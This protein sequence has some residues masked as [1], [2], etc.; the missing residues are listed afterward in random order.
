[1]S[2]PARRDADSDDADVDS[3]TGSSISI[4]NSSAGA[5][6]CTVAI[7]PLNSARS[8]DERRSANSRIHR[9]QTAR[10]AG[11]R[12]AYPPDTVRA[13]HRDAS[14]IAASSCVP[15][16]AR[17]RRAATASGATTFAHSCFDE[18]DAR[19]LE[20]AIGVIRAEP[21]PQA[22]RRARRARTRPRRS[23]HCRRLRSRRRS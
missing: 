10:A 13:R 1:M 15:V 23:F 17:D 8:R 16:S 14:T 19:A 9:E 5:I 22:V 12:R 4:S 11:A 20:T 3:S 7:V 6:S 21:D 2:S 18:R